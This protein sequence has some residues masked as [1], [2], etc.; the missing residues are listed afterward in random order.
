[1]HGVILDPNSS[2]HRPIT[3][4]RNG[5][6]RE[7]E[8]WLQELLFTHPELV[9]LDRID[10]DAGVFVPVCRELPLPGVGGSV[11]V[12]IFGLTP[13]GRPVLI[14]CKLWR[15][16]D[17]RRK[18]VGQILE[19][20]ALLQRWTYSDLQSRVANRLQMR[21]DNPLFDIVRGRHS[22]R[23]E[24]R[25]V[26]TV[27]NCLATGD[28]DLVIAG[29]GIRT[30]LHAIANFIENRTIARLA[31][32]EYQVWTDSTGPKVVL[33]SIPFR[34]EVVTRQVIVDQDGHAL[35]LSEP[36]ET[37]EE[38]ERTVNPA[39]AER[40][41]VNRQFWESLIQQAKF[42]HPDQPP[43]RHGGDNCVHMKLPP[44][45]RMTAYRSSDG[46]AGVWVTLE[47]PGAAA[48]YEGLLA[49]RGVINEEIAQT[50]EFGP[51]DKPGTFQIIARR[52]Y[53]AD[54]ADADN[55]LRR[56]LIDTADRF[57][58]AFRPRL[59]RPVS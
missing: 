13:A 3:H 31:L 25:F 38:V 22:D 20:A 51:G 58:T 39:A 59:G 40:R 56:W 46:T 17:A 10:P 35:K 19:Y 27:S 15:N 30:D 48:A 6:A 52:R 49:E 14:E 42:T 18:V 55:D 47:G 36:Q 11:F 57:V 1:M 50:L 24:A 26:E 34:D 2:T 16:P 21:A 53:D 33:P 28:F 41:S 4:S 7:R 43:P 45:G 37:Q 9:P 54:S 8:S 32:V 12:D 23:V 5:E 44:P 29:D